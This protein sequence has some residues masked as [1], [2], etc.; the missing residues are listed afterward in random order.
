MESHARVNA[1]R[2]HASLERVGRRL[3]S[4]LALTLDLAPTF[5]DDKF[6]EPMLALRLLRYRCI[7]IYL[8]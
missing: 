2:Y 7:S 5:F 4:L 6:D 3:A 1:D 8:R